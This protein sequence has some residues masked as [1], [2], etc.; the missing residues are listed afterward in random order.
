MK[1]FIL[2]LVIGGSGVGYVWQK[3]QIYQ[4]GK[5]IKAREMRLGVLQEQN[6]KMRLTL[7]GMRSRASLERRIKELNLGLQPP[8]PQAVWRLAEPQPD[9][10]PA[11]ESPEKQYAAG[12]GAHGAEA[13]P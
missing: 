1:A 6:E 7:S 8:A 11:N 3:N 12:K 2:C 9:S 5:Q 10:K 4:L 13:A